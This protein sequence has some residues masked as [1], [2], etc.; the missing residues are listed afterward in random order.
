[1]PEASAGEDGGILWG[2]CAGEAGGGIAGEWEEGR[3][4]EEMSLFEIVDG[5]V[6]RMLEECD[7]CETMAEC[8]ECRKCV[9]DLCVSCYKEGADVCEDCLK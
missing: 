3:E 5:K 4:A 1:M 9:R 7:G 8:S 2:V 6:V